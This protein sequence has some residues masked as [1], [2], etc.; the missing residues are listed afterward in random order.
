MSK[1]GERGGIHLSGNKTAMHQQSQGEQQLCKAGRDFQAW[2]GAAE[3]L[4]L[5][6]Y[7]YPRLQTQF[8]AEAAGISSCSPLFPGRQRR[9]DVGWDKI[10]VKSC[11][12]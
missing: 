11:I 1:L 12:L 3:S 2:L 6:F 9:E 8:P 5:I 7:P 10:D 4:N